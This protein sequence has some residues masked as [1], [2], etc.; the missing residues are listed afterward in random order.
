[1]CVWQWTTSWT[2][3]AGPACRAGITSVARQAHGESGST[4]QTLTVCNDG[5]LVQFYEMLHDSESK[6]KPPAPPGSTFC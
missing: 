6:T 4:V 2:S 1:M 3:A 5:S